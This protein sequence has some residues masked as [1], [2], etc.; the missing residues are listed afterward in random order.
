MIKAVA[1]CTCKKCGNEFK[2]FQ[3]EARDI[4]EAINWKQRAISHYTVCP[5]CW[6]APKIR[7][8]QEKLQKALS[9][10]TARIERVHYSVYKNEYSSCETVI[11]SYDQSTKT[12]EVIIK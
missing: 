3:Y 12:I 1:I 10:G 5:E 8:Q 9:D 7:K 6:Q 11:D 2:K 4:R